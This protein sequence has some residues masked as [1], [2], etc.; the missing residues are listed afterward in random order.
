MQETHYTIAFWGD[1]RGS[2]QEIQ[3]DVKRLGDFVSL[4]LV[5]RHSGPEGRSYRYLVEFR[6]ARVLGRYVLDEHDKVALIQSEAIEL[7]P[8]STKSN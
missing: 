6:Q 7:K 2:Q 3:A 5:E 8:A 1:I 4:T